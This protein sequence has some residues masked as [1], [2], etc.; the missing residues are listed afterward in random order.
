M[1]WGRHFRLLLVRTQRSKID[2]H[3]AWRGR[4]RTGDMRSLSSKEEAQLHLI[5]LDGLSHFP[6][7]LLRLSFPVTDILNKTAYRLPDGLLASHYLLHQYCTRRGLSEGS[8]HCIQGS[9][10]KPLSVESAFLTH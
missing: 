10:P 3:T 6:P 4:K 7:S 1:R 2:T 9:N 5:L 8:D